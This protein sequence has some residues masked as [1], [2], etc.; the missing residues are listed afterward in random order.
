MTTSHSRASAGAATGFA[1]LS[2]LEAVRAALRE[3]YDVLE[4]LG[5]GGLGA[6]FRARERELDREVAAKVLPLA[7]A[8][9][10]ELVE[11]FQREAR[12]AAALEHP[13]VVPVYRVGRAG[14]GGRAVYV[15]MK[16]LRGGSLAALL[17][18]RGRLTAREIRR[19]LAEAGSALG[20]AAGRGVVH[21][22]VKP[23]NI[24]VDEAGRF[25]V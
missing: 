25:V 18:A 12:A 5:R 14:E 22:G 3:E 10:A 2:E 11:R 17:R 16:Y 15:A 8:H 21:R 6:V 7:L 4:E 19:V 20:Y 13:N 23:A 9:D 24:L 1:G